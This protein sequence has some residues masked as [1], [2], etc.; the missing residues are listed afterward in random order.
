MNANPKI[1]DLLS[2]VDVL[3]SMNDHPRNPQRWTH[4]D[5]QPLN[6]QEVAL[7]RQA[8]VADFRAVQTLAQLQADDHA[9]R[10][11]DWRRLDEL[12]QPRFDAGCETVNDCVGAMPADQRAEAEDLIAVLEVDG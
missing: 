11:R 12:L 5:G 6:Q 2:D 9:Q 8:T 1:V 3:R 4:R 10:I 7:A